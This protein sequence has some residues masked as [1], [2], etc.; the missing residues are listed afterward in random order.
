MRG[1]YE[2]CKAIDSI[3]FFLRKGTMMH[4]WSRSE[5]H[6]QLTRNNNFHLGELKCLDLCF[7]TAMADRRVSWVL[8]SYTEVFIGWEISEPGSWFLR[9]DTLAH[10]KRMSRKVNRLDCT[11]I[12]SG[13]QYFGWRVLDGGLT[14]RKICTLCW[15][16][17]GWMAFLCDIARDEE[18]RPLWCYR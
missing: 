4:T 2:S 1:I 10:K 13:L 16:G 11:C 3:Q 18:L 6:N 5:L 15:S 8:I 14:Q 7:F 17:P 12:T 9:G